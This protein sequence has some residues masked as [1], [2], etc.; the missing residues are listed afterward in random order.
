MLDTVAALRRW[1]LNLL[2]ADNLIAKRSIRGRKKAA[3]WDNRYLIHLLVINLDAC[4]LQCTFQDPCRATGNVLRNVTIAYH[5]R[6][7]L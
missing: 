5:T 2:K 3:G 7:T 6:A 4:A 1:A